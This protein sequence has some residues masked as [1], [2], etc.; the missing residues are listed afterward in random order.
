MQAGARGA[1]EAC[2]D[3]AVVTG[4]GSPNQRSVAPPPHVDDHRDEDDEHPSDE[5]V[6]SPSAIG[7]GIGSAFWETL[8]SR[9]R[10]NFSAAMCVMFKMISSS[11]YKL[12]QQQ[13]QDATVTN[14]ISVR[15]HN[16][17]ALAHRDSLATISGRG[18]FPRNQTPEVQLA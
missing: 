18:T 6:R 1:A 14:T 5:R 4:G 12:R 3:D 10:G 9:G 7:V 2:E 15:L 8:A 11:S 17:I 13:R 16:I